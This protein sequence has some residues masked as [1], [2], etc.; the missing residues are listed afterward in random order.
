MNLKGALFEPKG[1]EPYH[2]SGVVEV[3]GRTYSIFAFDAIS[4]K[5]LPYIQLSLYEKNTNEPMHQTHLRVD[6]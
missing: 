4:K 2:Y 6:D 1:D 5:G 3:E